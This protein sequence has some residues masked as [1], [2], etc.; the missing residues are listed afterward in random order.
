MTTYHD[1]QGSQLS[2]SYVFS[3]DEI[4]KLFYFS[5]VNKPTILSI[6]PFTVMVMNQSVQLTKLIKSGLNNQKKIIPAS[7]TLKFF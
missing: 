1:K 6:D 4:F 2:K 3:N 7:P 5:R